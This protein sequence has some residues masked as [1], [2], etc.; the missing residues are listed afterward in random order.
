MA[1][2]FKTASKAACCNFMC[3]TTVCM[4][5]NR[6]VQYRNDSPGP[7]PANHLHDICHDMDYR[8]DGGD[9]LF[10]RN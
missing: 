2:L 7:K 9:A 8:A 6:E 3:S 5:G 10:G 4:C 1:N